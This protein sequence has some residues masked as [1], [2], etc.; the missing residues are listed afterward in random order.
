MEG[1]Y[2]LIQAHRF[3]LRESPD[4]PEPENTRKTIMESA[5]ERHYGDVEMKKKKWEVA[6]APNQIMSAVQYFLSCEGH[7]GSFC[8]AKSGC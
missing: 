3:C 2:V 5:R 8:V 4:R 6:T 7:L 1:T